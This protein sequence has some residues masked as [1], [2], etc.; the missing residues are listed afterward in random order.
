LFRWKRSTEKKKMSGRFAW[1][2]GEE[3]LNCE[4][5]VEDG[6]R[7]GRERGRKKTHWWEKQD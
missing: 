6:T 4:E 5:R 7:R 2:G 3:G 1:G